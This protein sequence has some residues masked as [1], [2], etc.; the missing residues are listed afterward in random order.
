MDKPWEYFDNRIR[1]ASL[2]KRY[3]PFTKISD[4]VKPAILDSL[5]R[6]E[7]INDNRVIYVHIPFCNNICP[8]C[9]YHKQRINDNVTISAYCNAVIKQIHLLSPAIWLNSA[10]FK[11]I[12]FGGGTPTS[13]PVEYLESIIM[14]VKQSYPLTDDCEITVESTISDITPE[15]VLRLKN[16]GVNRISLG[17]QTFNSSLRKTLGRSA[18]HQKI[19]DTIAFISQ[20]GIS[21]ICIDL[22]YNLKGQNF[23]LWQNDLSLLRANPITGCSVYPL[24]S[25][26]DRE[27][28][29]SEKPKESLEMEY[30]YFIEAD[31][32]LVENI[33]WDR[34]TS[35]QYG[36]QDKGKA[37]YVTAQGQNADVLAFGSGAAGRINNFNY[38]Q[39]GN[40]VEYIKG[41]GDF[42][43][44][45]ITFMTIQDSF[46][47]YREIYSL[48]ESLRINNY[49]YQGLKDYFDDIISKLIHN[50]LIVSKDDS[51][52][53]TQ[54]GRFW[55]GNI[56]ELF[57]QRIRDLF[58]LNEKRT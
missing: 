26:S 47:K 29:N 39:T 43:N 8:F 46:L 12:Y 57:T 33:G 42:M 37:V 19:A 34:F 28:P 44:D 1:S 41:S 45:S 31:N 58:L 25:A 16:A 22:I 7:A 54:A 32:R 24:V 27:I 15:M 49:T 23:D 13:I 14:A 3:L 5:F 18:D 9:I 55:A 52:C 30:N 4:I 51:I 50:G 6:Q 2:S 56:S 53:L 11:V 38:I 48:S 36:H 40:I 21:N 20:N 17:I 10:P 35:V